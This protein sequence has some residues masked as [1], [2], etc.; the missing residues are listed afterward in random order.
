MFRDNFG[1]HNW[2][3]MNRPGMLL[4]NLQCIGSSLQQ[5]YPAQNATSTEIQKLWFRERVFRSQIWESGL[6]WF[7]RKVALGWSCTRDQVHQHTW[8]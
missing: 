7:W 4:I 5:D 3:L 6:D 1:C 8:G 2:Y